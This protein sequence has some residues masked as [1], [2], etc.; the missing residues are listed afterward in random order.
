[1]TVIGAAIGFFYNPLPRFALTGAII[2]GMTLSPMSWWFYKHGRINA[3]ARP[4]NIFYENTVTMDEKERILSL[5]QM[6][7]LAEKMA[8]TTA[9]GYFVND[10]THI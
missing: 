1:M 3:Q 4:S 5:D 9:Y 10:Q 6:E 7:T 8:S 2:A